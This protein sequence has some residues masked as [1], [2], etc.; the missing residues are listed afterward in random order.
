MAI[1]YICNQINSLLEDK[2]A[3]S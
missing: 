1:D 2:C 3:I